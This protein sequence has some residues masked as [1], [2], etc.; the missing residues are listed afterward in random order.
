MNPTEEKNTTNKQKRRYYPS[1]LSLSHLKFRRDWREKLPRNISRFTGYRPLD[2]NPPYPPLPFPPFTWLAKL[3]LRYETWLLAWIGAFIGILLIE[4]IMSTSTAFRDVYHAPTIITSFGASAVLLFGVIESP[5]AQP[6]NFV[7]GHFLSALVGT[8]ISRLFVLNGKYQG[9]L[10]NVAF[11]PST[12]VN[13]GVSMATALLVML[14]TGTAHPPAGATALNAAVQSQIVSLSWRYLPTVLASSLIML[15]WAIIINNVG[16]RR[17]PLHWWAPG[18]VFVLPPEEQP[19]AQLRAQEE[20]LEEAEIQR[21]VTEEGSFR[22]ESDP[23]ETISMERDGRREGSVYSERR[24]SL[25][26]RRGSV[27][28]AANGVV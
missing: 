12:F 14:V 15:G 2:E 23:S 13:G 8:A 24:G 17:Y 19:D 5:V 9:Y 7:L 26:E 10:D 20:A 11:H 25:H 18:P 28:S 21:E 3:P 6:R 22:S 4:A 16:R 27:G 1:L